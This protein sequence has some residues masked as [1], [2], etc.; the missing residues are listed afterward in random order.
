VMAISFSP[1]LLSS[2]VVYVSNLSLS[3]ILVNEFVS[4]VPDDFVIVS[5]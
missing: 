5:W 3:F 4:N 1:I 2:G